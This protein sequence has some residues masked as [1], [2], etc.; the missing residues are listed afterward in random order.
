M[1]QRAEHEW[2]QRRER[3]AGVAVV[4]VL[5]ERLPEEDGLG[6]DAGSRGAEAEIRIVGPGQVHERRDD[7]G[8]HGHGEE[9][10]REQRQRVESRTCSGANPLDPSS[11]SRVPGL[12]GCSAPALAD[13]RR[14]C[15]AGERFVSLLETA[16]ARPRSRPA[17]AAARRNRR[18]AA[19]AVAA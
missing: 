6:V 3:Q 16:T 13:A 8:H 12:S 14:D 19:A 15:H 18:A 2:E 1:M 17:P 4:R 11:V 5:E 7:A 9:E 10:R